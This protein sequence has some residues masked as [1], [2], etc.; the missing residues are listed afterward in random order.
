MRRPAPSVRA[1]FTLLLAVSMPLAPLSA[2]APATAE[3]AAA[4]VENSVVKIFSTA[5]GP[6][7][8][9]PWSKQSP[10]EASGSGV[11]IEGKRIL[12]N[13]HVVAYASQIQVQGNQSGEKIAATVESISPAM[14][15]A[16]LKLED[17]SFFDTRPALPRATVLPAI[18]DA[19]LTYGFPTGGASLA[20]TKGI[21][22]R[23]EFT[24]YGFPASGLRIQIDAAINPGNSG[25]PALSGDKMIGLAFS[26]LGGGD[27]I[28]YIIPTEEIEL[29]LKD[30][31]DG[32]Y[33][34]KPLMFDELQ[35]LQNPALRAYLKL[36]RT[37]SGILV[38][39]PD[40]AAADYPLKAWDVITK[41]GDTSIDDEGMIKLGDN[42]RVRFSYLIQTLA[43]NGKVAL[44]V[45][46][47][48]QPVPIELPVPNTRT[49]LIASLDNEYPPYFA[50]G[51]LVFSIP[52]TQLLGVS[53]SGATSVFNAWARNGSP[54]VTRRSDRPAFEGEQ[55]VMVSA[56][57]LPHKLGRGY[58]NPVMR[59]VQS[60][61][62]VTVKN[63]SHLVELLR[64]NREEF[65]VFKFFG[66]EADSIVLA[67]SE[68]AAATE[69]LLNDNGIRAQGS[70]S[71][72]EIWNAKK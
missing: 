70:A 66:R 51:P 3:P 56:P 57:L 12:T 54:L 26:R 59:V 13:A 25:G 10:R 15:L 63:L 19:V 67:R 47:H 71:L 6:D 28:G 68:V 48:G 11:V 53:S 42:L 36:D 55:L 24:S 64:D 14:D 45:V 72:L 16:V 60:V 32:R 17:E 52:S 31:A 69:D 34:G 44:T 8:L 9:R 41:I 40:N 27:N 62:G 18:K 65:I 61:N 4:M 49:M 46:R 35:P 23:I 21:V 58:S 38:T 7:Q 2:Q 33:D 22:S 5:R 50:Y 39:K 29:F 30:V 20:I 43:R 37:V 1:F